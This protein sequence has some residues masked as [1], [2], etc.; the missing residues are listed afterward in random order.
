MDEGGA[1]PVVEAILVAVLVLTAILFFTSVQRPTKGAESRGQDLG[2]V[3]T[4]TIGILQRRT[5]TVLADPT[6]CPGVTPPAGALDFEAWVTQV[7]QGECTTAR[8]VDAF[9][10]DVLPAGSHHQLRLANGA[11]DLVLLPPPTKDPGTPQ[12]AR[13]AQL[14]FFPHWQAF[15]ASTA[16]DLGAPTQGLTAAGDPVL[17]RF[18]D[19]LDIKCVKAPYDKPAGTPAVDG[20]YAP[21]GV[22]WAA[23]WQSQ[24]LAA[25]M[26]GAHT[27]GSKVVTGLAT[28]SGLAPGMR[29]QGTGITGAP[30]TTIATVDSATQV[31]LSAN[32]AAT[33]TTT[34][35]F[36]APAATL[37]GTLSTANALVTGLSSTAA[38]EV[39]MHVAGTGTATQPTIVSVDSATQV[40]LSANSGSN[41]ALPVTFWASHVPSGL[42]FGTWAGY[43]DTACS[44]GAVYGSITLPGARS[45]TDAV[46]S[47]TPKTFLASPTA[48]FTADDLGKSVAG[49]N[50]PGGTTIA[51]LGRKVA[52]AVTTSGSI[53]VTS[54]T[55]AFVAGDV[56][57]PVSGTNIPATATV[58]V[59]NS[60]TSIQVS[61][62]A[63]ASGSSL[64]LT[65]LAPNQVT[66]SKAATATGT[67]TA[68]FAQDPTYP[69]YGIQLVVWFGA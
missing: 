25:S 38:L 48:G 14:P 45:V 10:D 15:A 5:F 26:P 6:N 58:T 62:A 37:T 36:A 40:T 13:A 67:F 19:Q 43:T 52:D 33:G 8:S 21:G 51:A 22:P 57:Q 16:T 61:Q 53:T 54:A 44:A 28:T 32:A 31:T 20:R 65:V 30:A 42:P 17:A 12:G 27:S 18:A 55:A 60:A 47:G 29:V 11:D 59:I 3:A 39:G 1:F 68:S 66:L 23:V 49:P 9:L 69:M 24:A 63:T 7:M 34:L 4:D 64:P 35:L 50:F 2:Q 46:V 56:G 41:G